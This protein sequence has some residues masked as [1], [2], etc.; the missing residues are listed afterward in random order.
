MCGYADVQMIL[1][2]FGLISEGFFVAV[3]PEK[4]Q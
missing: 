1:E 4:T 2:A 3:N